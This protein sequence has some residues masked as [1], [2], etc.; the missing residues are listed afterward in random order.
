MPD[1]DFKPSAINCNDLA[2]DSPFDLLY[3]LIAWNS[4]AIPVTSAILRFSKYLSPSAIDCRFGP[5]LTTFSDE[6]RPSACVRYSMPEKSGSVIPTSDCKPFAS[7]SKPLAFASNPFS[8]TPAI[9]AMILSLASEICCAA[10]PPS[11]AAC[12]ACSICWRYSAT[13]CAIEASGLSVMSICLTASSPNSFASSSLNSTS[14]WCICVNASLSL[15]LKVV[16]NRLLAFCAI[17][18]NGTTFSPSCFCF[19]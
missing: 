11:V 3:S 4:D 10:V 7:E 14:F 12:F 18:S 13:P 19:T 1:S 6:R 15:S 17:T 2:A 16:P 5:A 8:E 9:A